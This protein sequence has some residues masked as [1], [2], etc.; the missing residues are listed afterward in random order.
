MSAFLATAQEVRAMKRANRNPTHNWQL[1]Y[2]PHVVQPFMIAPILPGETLKHA[3]IQTRTV[4][5]PI[6]NPLVGWWNEHW[7]FFVPLQGL[8]DKFRA[9][10]INPEEDMSSLDD[11]THVDYYHENTS[12]GTDINYAKRCTEAI[13]DNFFRAE[14]E[15]SSTSGTTLTSVT[16][17]TMPMAGYHQDWY[18]DS[19]INDDDYV[20]PAD[21]NL[22]DAGSEQG[23][24]VYISEIANA[25]QRWELMRYHNLTQLTFE[26]YCASHWG[27]TA[28]PEKNNVP[29]LLRYSGDWTYPTNTIDPTNGTPRSA[30]SWSKRF[31][32]DK[33]RLFKEPG[34]IVGVTTSRPKVYLKNLSS[35]AVMLMKSAKSWLPPSLMK[36]PHASMTRV[37]AGDA[38]L[39]ANTDDYWVDINDIF[40]HGDQFYNFVNTATDANFVSSPVAGGTDVGRRFPTSADLDALFVSASPANQI[41][42]DG[43]CNLTIASRRHTDTS[44]NGIG[45]NL[46]LPA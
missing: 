46:T 45:N 37:A 7:L 8:S 9:M 43:T 27:G 32:A 26:E 12:S 1:R 18:I 5:D 14:G 21:E 3:M 34:F 6:K 38:P 19:A 44:P 40:Q 20:P 29:E 23:T 22:T 24:A 15:T 17:A 2:R 10:V 28:V 16:T 4:S 25:M 33:A 42:E 11:A 35:S 39:T 41:R 31:S 36:D 13:V 30:V